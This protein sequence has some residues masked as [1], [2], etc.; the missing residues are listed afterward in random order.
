MSFIKLQ[1]ENFD[2]FSLTLRPR[3]E[4]LSSSSGI[5]GAARLA[6]RPSSFNREILTPDE[7]STDPA[8]FDAGLG[9]L[10]AAL[11]EAASLSGVAKEAALK[12]YMASV[13]SNSVN[14]KNNV[15][16]PILRLTQSIDY[17]RNSLIKSTIKNVLMPQYR[18]TYTD[19][20]YSYK[21][22]H[23]INFFT[24]S[25]V[26]NNSA[27]IYPN[28]NDQY[29]L[30]DSFS[31]DFYINPRYLSAPG[32]EFNAGSI[33]HMS[34][35]FCLSLLTGSHKNADGQNDR[36]RL[37]IA[38]KHSSDIPPS[39]IDTSVSNGT[40]P[41]PQDLVYVSDDNMLKHNH[42][43]HVTVRWSASA[44]NRTGSFQVDNVTSSF[45]YPSGSVTGG[46]IPQ[47][48]FMGNQYIGVDDTRKFFNSTTAGDQGL[49]TLI[50]GSDPTAFTLN[51]PLNAEIH[52]VKIY[53]R[54]ITAQ[55]AAKN[56]I[57]APSIEDDGLAF[58]VPPFFT[59]SSVKEQITFKTPTYTEKIVPYAPYNEN[60]ST[61]AQVFYPN[62]Q[63]FLID[64]KNPDV[65]QP[66]LYGMEVV[67]DPTDSEATAAEHMFVQP[68]YARRVYTIM[69][70][71]NG[72][73]IPSYDFILTASS[74]PLY[75]PY[76]TRASQDNTSI[77]LEVI[78]N[79]IKYNSAGMQTVDMTTGGRASYMSPTSYLFTSTLEQIA[80]LAEGNLTTLLSFS[81]SDISGSNGRFADR[82][83][84]LS[85]I[86]Q[87]SNLY[88]GNQIFPESFTI[89]STAL[90]GSGGKINIT[91]KD[92]GFGGLYRADAVTPPPTWATVGNL[93]YDEGLAIIKSPHLYYFGKDNFSVSFNGSQNIH[94]YTIDAICPAGEINSSSNPSY[95]SFPPTNEQNETADNFV[96]ITGINI[97][98]D[99]FNVIMR[100]NLAQPVL[101]RPDEEFLF[102]IKYDM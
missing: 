88:Y 66:R 82:S 81:G 96:Y 42:W 52:D 16:I 80:A 10:D 97:H 11:N 39:N 31:F 38:F 14:Q 89:S 32:A 94:T 26:S 64:L 53:K 50:G 3:T 34:S 17:D 84:N 57:V 65:S 19:C 51:S 95:L 73:F 55:E 59:N 24:S 15:V 9:S 36:F 41:F 69:P 47:V 44:Y 76:K 85:T 77:S 75:N 22:Y 49:I 79:N 40:R 23:T 4:F 60:I 35:S 6:I 90:T 27:I 68:S 21:N 101:K 93:F 78:D 56:A 45:I 37:A 7:I 102:R 83:S 46:S 25:A 2:T 43:H 28:V 33:L 58:Y 63:N 54:Y 91:L 18:S 72:L 1:P 98:D 92:N 67:K 61:Q 87:I 13:N 48:L 12:S 20:D 70:N 62:I 74:A 29:T 86:Y 99:N 71:D 8:T 100:A 5:Y 30:G